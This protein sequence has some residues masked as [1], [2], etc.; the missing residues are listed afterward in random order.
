LISTL[1]MVSPGIGPTISWKQFLSPV[2][3]ENRFGM[4]RGNVDHGNMELD[5]LFANRPFAD[6][7]NRRNQ[8]E[9]LYLCGS[10]AHP[11]GLV[12]GAPGYN[13]A[14]QALKEHGGALPG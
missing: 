7:S 10:G 13:A 6:A 12:S 5:N 3:I 11:G 8:I 4:H 9:N 14:F 1:E 2:D